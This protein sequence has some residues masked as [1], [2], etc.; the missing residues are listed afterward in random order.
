MPRSSEKQKYQRF[1]LD[2]LDIM[3]PEY[4]ARRQ[5][6]EENDVADRIFYLYLAELDDIQQHRY[7]FREEYRVRPYDEF[8]LVLNQE[9]QG[10]PWINDTEF[11]GEFR[12]NRNNFD[13]LVGLIENDNIFWSNDNNNSPNAIVGNVATSTNCVIVR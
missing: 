13:M 2:Q 9:N 6:S 12:M 1:I 8:S 5:N 3:L 10:T 11:L 4:V 7:L